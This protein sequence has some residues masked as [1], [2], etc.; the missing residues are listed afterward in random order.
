MVL[1]AL[2]PLVAGSATLVHGQEPPR[3][4]VAPAP[5]E[6]AFKLVDAY[7]VSNL[8]ESLGLSDE[9][10]VKVLPLLKRVQTARRQHLLD[11]T[12]L[13]RELRQKLRAGASTEAEVIETLRELKSVDARGVEQARVAMVELDAALTPLQQAKY[14]VLELEVEQRMR[15]LVGRVRPR[16]GEGRAPQP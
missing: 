10:F 12:R 15:E 11:R 7:V 2:L 8:Q 3:R 16:A 5:R 4:R 9:A 14:R 6:E 13:Q 1:W